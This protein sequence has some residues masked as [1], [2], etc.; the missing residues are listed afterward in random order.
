MKNMANPKR[1]RTGSPK[2]SASFA[3]IPHASQN[4]HGNLSSFRISPTYPVVKKVNFGE[5]A[6]TTRWSPSVVALQNTI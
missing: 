6:I 1:Y 4:V 2:E 5:N 3:G